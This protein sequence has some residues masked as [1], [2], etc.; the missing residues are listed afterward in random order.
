LGK[1]ILDIAQ[2]K[3]VALYNN[4]KNEFIKAVEKNK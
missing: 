4:V 2:L 1:Q 3:K